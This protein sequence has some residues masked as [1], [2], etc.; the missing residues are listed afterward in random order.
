MTS[1]NSFT[2][3][4]ILCSF[5]GR[6]VDHTLSYSAEVKERVGLYPYS[7]S[8]PSWPVLG[9]HYVYLCSSLGEAYK[10]CAF[11]ILRNGL[12]VLYP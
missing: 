11:R 4:I 9:G 6:G 3:N 12:S 8:G 1:H 10:T 2:I 7:T 5:L